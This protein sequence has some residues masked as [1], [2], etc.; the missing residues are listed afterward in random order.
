MNWKDYPMF[1]NLRFDTGTK[2][3]P[4]LMDAVLSAP[5]GA[6]NSGKK[7]I[8]GGPLSPVEPVYA[9]GAIAYNPFWEELLRVDFAGESGAIADTAVEAGLSKDFS[10]ENLLAAGITAGGKNALPVQALSTVCGCTDDQVKKTLQTMA[11][12]SG[13]P[14]YFWEVPRYDVEFSGWTRNFIVK[15]LNQLFGW[16]QSQT[17][18]KLNERDLQVSIKVSNSLRQDIS[19]I[20]A[21]LRTSTMVL[22]PLEY[23]ILHSTAGMF[24]DSG[25]LIHN[26]YRD[27]ISELKLKSSVAAASVKKIRVYWVGD[28]TLDLELFNALE[29]YGAYLVGSDSRLP[30]YYQMINETG[31]PVENLA[32]WVW[33]MPCNLSIQERMKLEIPLILDQKPDAVILHRTAGSRN[34][35]ASERMVGDIIKEQTALPVLYLETSAPGQDTEKINSQ[36]NGFV[37]SVVQ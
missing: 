4:E 10:L 3:L 33:R 29:D 2:G 34:T 21:L 16:L 7:I 24:L 22:S 19:E 8:A 11:S 26:C 12:V 14:L 5:E 27:V 6:K 17:G 36:I 25:E 35:A 28:G 32:N 9:A 20:D 18:R 13:A 1:K 23:H 31:N 37:K 15:E 30:F